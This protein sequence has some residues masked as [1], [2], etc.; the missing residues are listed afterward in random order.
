MNPAGIAPHRREPPP[1]AD[2]GKAC[3]DPPPTRKP[4][5]PPEVLRPGP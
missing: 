5:Q 3:L 2:Q 4:V 1:P